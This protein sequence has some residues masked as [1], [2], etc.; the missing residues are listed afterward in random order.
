[1]STSHETPPFPIQIPSCKSL[2]GLSAR[3]PQRGTPRPFVPRRAL[4]VREKRLRGNHRGRHHRGGRR[5][6][7]YFLQLL[8]E[9]R[10]RS[11]GI[12]RNAAGKIGNN[13]PEG[14]K[15]RL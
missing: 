8:P 11:D 3:P 1:M 9:Q 10:A 5:R 15:I 4:S 14:K 7:R 6:Q 12:W 13:R 2:S